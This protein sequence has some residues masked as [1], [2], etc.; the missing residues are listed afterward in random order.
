[1]SINVIKIELL[2]LL[3]IVLLIIFNRIESNVKVTRM[4]YF[5]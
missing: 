5:I 4:N 3:E 1:M 2:K